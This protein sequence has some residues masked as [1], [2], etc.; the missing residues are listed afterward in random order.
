MAKKTAQA[1]TLSCKIIAEWEEDFSD[2]P[3]PES[4]VQF[5]KMKERAVM[6]ASLKEGRIPY[7]P[8]VMKWL[9][10]QLGKPSSRITQAD[11]D[12]LLN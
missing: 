4:K 1:E 11:V 3:A 8:D 7:A 12:G 2:A 6:I 5:P 9:S 10:E